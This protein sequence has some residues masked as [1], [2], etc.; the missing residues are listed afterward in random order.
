LHGVARRCFWVANGDHDL[1]SYGVEQPAYLVH[2]T[3]MNDN[4]GI[5]TRTD[6]LFSATLSRLSLRFADGKSA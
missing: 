6:V 2:I 5:Q 3:F 4:I 1:F